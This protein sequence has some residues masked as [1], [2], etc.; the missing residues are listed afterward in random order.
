VTSVDGKVKRV[1]AVTG[2]QYFYLE[3]VIRIDRSVKGV[4]CVGCMETSGKTD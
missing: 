2:E 1:G 3:D 4:R